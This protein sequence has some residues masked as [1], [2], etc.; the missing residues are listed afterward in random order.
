MPIIHCSKNLHSQSD[1]IGLKE[2]ESHRIRE[3]KNSGA[4]V[5][6]GR[7]NQ[8]GSDVRKIKDTRE[9]GEKQGGWKR[10]SGRLRKLLCH[11]FLRFFVNLRFGNSEYT[12]HRINA[13]NGR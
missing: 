4:L 1:H 13:V 7:R 11:A 10:K 8:Q 12:S 5:F 2:E 3:N 6:R 9:G